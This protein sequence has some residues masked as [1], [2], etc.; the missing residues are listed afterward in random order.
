MSMIYSIFSNYHTVASC[1]D[2][3]IYVFGPVYNFNVIRNAAGELV[4]SFPLHGDVK[5]TFDSI[6]NSG[7]WF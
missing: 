4:Y 5:A 2:G 3:Y 6:I 7:I 1:D